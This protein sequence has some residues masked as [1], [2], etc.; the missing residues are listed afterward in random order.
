M[1]YISRKGSYPSAENE[2]LEHLVKEEVWKAVLRLPTKLREVM[3]LYSHHQLSVSEI[4]HLLA[5]PEGTVKT[6]LHR[7]RTK[8]SEPL[9]GSEQNE[10]I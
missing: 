3:V 10:A 4:A 9:K 5:I 8:I 6:R 7:A 1:E 2:V